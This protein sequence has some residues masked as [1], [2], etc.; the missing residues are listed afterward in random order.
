MSRHFTFPNSATTT[1][2][3]PVTVNSST[4]PLWSI[5]Y[6]LHFHRIFIQ[7]SGPLVNSIINPVM[8]AKLQIDVGLIP[9]IPFTQKIIKK[10]KCYWEICPLLQ[11]FSE[12]GNWNDFYDEKISISGCVAGKEV[13]R[14]K[15]GGASQTEVSC[16]QFSDW[17][18]QEIFW[19]DSIWRWLG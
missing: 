8:D 13:W 12:I 17:N 10:L 1:I 3:H 5:N 14:C 7:C 19:D 6:L 18:W 15:T 2:Q 9:L 4:S 11:L 16:S